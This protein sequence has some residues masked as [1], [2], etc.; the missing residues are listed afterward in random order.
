M[1]DIAWICRPELNEKY[2]PLIRSRENIKII[3][4]TIDLHYLRMK[5]AWELSPTK[6][7]Q[8]AT[9]WVNMQARE[10]KIAH[11]VDLTITVTPVEKEILQQQGIDSVEV[12]PNIHLDHTSENR[13]FDTSFSGR[14]NILFIGS[15]NHPPNVD[16]VLWLCRE[17]MPLVWKQLPDVKVTLL[18]SNPTEQVQRLT[19]DQVTVTG[20]TSDVSEYF[21]S[22]RIFV[23]PLRY[24]AGMKGKIGQSLEYSLPII[25][26]AIGIEGMS[27]NHEENILEANTTEEFVRQI[28]RLYQ[29][30]GLW[31]YLA[32]NCREAI[33]SFAPEVIK[34]KILSIMENLTI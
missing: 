5:R 10:L 15:Y 27:L 7:V 34:Q 23:S 32:S 9:E 4:D 14:K 2:L 17:I 13:G 22:H 19:S 25:S 18:G 29:T 24:G 12:V 16:A 8:G 26:T 28:L 6:D 3:Y 1:I 31:N 11:Q 20:Y 33:T 21:F 30:E